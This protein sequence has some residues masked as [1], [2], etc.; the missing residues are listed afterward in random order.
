[1]LT[2]ALWY[3]PANDSSVVKTS[4]NQSIAWTK[5]FLQVPVVPSKT[6]DAWN[7]AWTTIAT[8]AQVY[9]KQDKLTTQT[10]YTSKWT[11]TKV[12]T[13]TTNTLW[14]VTGITETSI[15]FPCNISKW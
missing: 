8:E 13:I 15:A 7:N 10:A 12:T 11:S 2:T 6:T 5:T 4:W 3:T 1:M 9:K 14:Q